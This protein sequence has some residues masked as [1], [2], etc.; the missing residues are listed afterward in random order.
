MCVVK[1]TQKAGRVTYTCE[2]TGL[3]IEEH[4]PF[5]AFCPK[6]CGFDA[7]MFSKMRA[8]QWVDDMGPIFKSRFEE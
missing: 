4:T 1:R 7:A 3:P 6:R 8:E 5:G 2:I